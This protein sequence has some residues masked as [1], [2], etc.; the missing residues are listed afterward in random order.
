MPVP[1]E[2]ESVVKAVVR[3]VFEG[4]RGQDA[5]ELRLDLPEMNTVEAFH[6]NWERNADREERRHS[7]FALHTIKPDEVAKE[8]EATDTVLGDPEA[9]RH[10]MVNAAQRL[11]FSIQKRTGYYELDPAGL[12]SEIRDRLGWRKPVKA[13]F[14]SPPPK[15]IEG[16][17]VLGRNHPLIAFLSD[18]ILGRAFLPQT[19]QDYSRCGAAYTSAVKVRTVIALLR[20]RYKLQRRAQTEQFAEEV[21]T[22]ASRAAGS[23]LAWTAPNDPAM[24]SLL[25]SATPA[26]NISP[27][28]KQQRIDRALD[29]MLTGASQLQAIADA[30]ATEL[31][32]TY[33]RLKGTIGGGQVGVSAY[34]PD[35]LGVYVLLPG[36]NA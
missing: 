18:R 12:P 1:A 16:A 32:A 15:N 6:Q 8:I 33:D 24:L 7:R 22:V 10:F 13:V 3:A 30:R 2:S 4:W 25:K 28:E 35:L 14:V 5:Q 34:P 11:K 23:S 21:I 29:E 36:G 20:V 9:V 17:V 31:E 26:G 19:D 27:Q